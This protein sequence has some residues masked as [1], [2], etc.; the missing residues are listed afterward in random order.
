M[1]IR[2]LVAS[3][4]VMLT[5][6]GVSAQSGTER[7]AEDTGKSIVENVVDR[8]WG[9]R[10]QK[11]CTYYGALIFAEATGNLEI[12][13]QMEEGYALYDQGKRKPRRG[14]VDYNV[15]GIWPLELYRQTGNEDY[16]KM[17]LDLADHENCYG[18]PLFQDSSYRTLTPL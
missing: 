17:G 12:T 3:L 15:F 13:S 1:K 6:N 5:A 8:Y 10:Y 9:W 2:T 4:L 18:Q 16:L 7:S 14:H 11:A